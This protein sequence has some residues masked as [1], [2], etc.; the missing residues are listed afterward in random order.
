MAPS[1]ST[2]GSWRS[3]LG[4]DMRRNWRRD[5]ALSNMGRCVRRVRWACRFFII[6]MPPGKIVR[7]FYPLG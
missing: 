5:M 7:I 4:R 6:F 3:T 2:P 1:M